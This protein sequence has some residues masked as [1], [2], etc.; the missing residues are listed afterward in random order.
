MIDRGKQNVLGI[1][2][3][4]VDYET[5]VDEVISS[6]QRAQ[7]LSVTALAVH[8]VMT[9]VLDKV[10][11]H[12]LNRLDRV[13]PDGQPVRWALNSLHKVQLNDR[14]YGPTL[15][16][17]ICERA[18]D[19]RL[20]I[21]LFGGDPTT[22][23]ALRHSLAQRF[24]DLLVAGV[25]P[26]KF[27]R[28]T[29]AEREEMVQEVRASGARILFVGLGCPRQEVFVYERARDFHMPC[30]AVGAAFPFHAGLIPQAPTWMQQMGLEWLFRLIQ[31]PSR[32]WKRYVLLNPAYATL[33][34]LQ[35]VG[36]RRPDV[37]DT[38]EPTTQGSFG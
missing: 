28:L 7:P 31:E 25:R 12:R 5:V 14:V 33:L 16:L 18:V 15:M 22:V 38:L 37:N 13:C 6:A 26:S 20:P 32:L 1:L 10:Q 29:E 2:I 4:A 35:K 27:R 24:P 17:K 34:L 19:E 8:G 30:V 23:E 21:F 9:G 36:L 11:R 3:D